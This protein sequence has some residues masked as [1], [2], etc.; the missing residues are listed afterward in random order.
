[1][2]ITITGDA[3]LQT[4]QIKKIPDTSDVIESITKSVKIILENYEFDFFNTKAKYQIEKDIAKTESTINKL[5][6]LKV[7]A[8]KQGKNLKKQYKQAIAENDKLKNKL[9]SGLE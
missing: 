7:A 4:E 8:V 3:A 9:I 6:E 2:S 5:I 1:M